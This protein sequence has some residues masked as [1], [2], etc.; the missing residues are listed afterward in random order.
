MVT[1]IVGQCTAV[2]GICGRLPRFVREDIG[3]QRRGHARRL[4]RRIPARVLQDVREAVDE[5]CVGRRVAAEVG[6]LLLARREEDGLRRP[7]AAVGLHP[8]AVPVAAGHEDPMPERDSCRSSERLIRQLERDAAHVLVGEEVVAGE[9][10]FVQGT[11]G[12]E[13]ERVAAPTREEPVLT[14]LRHA[15]V[16]AGRDRRFLHDDVALFADPA[17]LV[18]LDAAYRCGLCAVRRREARAEGNV[19][20]TV[21]VRVDLELVHRLG[22]ERLLRRGPGRIDADGRVHVDHQDRSRRA[23]GH[24]KGEQV[25]V[26]DAGISVRERE[27]GP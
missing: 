5:A 8:V 24:G 14:A 19:G 7:R 10:E 21:A 26:V 15:R 23:I 17:C 13:E 12:I 2:A 9:L 20:D 25:G 1:D 22:C 3:Q 27:I 11:L 18:P 6:G 16:R 4:V